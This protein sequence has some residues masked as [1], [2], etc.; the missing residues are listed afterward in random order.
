MAELLMPAITKIWIEEL[1]NCCFGLVLK[2]T[3]LPSNCVIVIA[4]CRAY[5]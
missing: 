3:I 5:S 2:V 4:D 1:R